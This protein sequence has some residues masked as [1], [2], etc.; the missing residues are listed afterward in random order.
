MTIANAESTKQGPTPKIEPLFND[1]FIRIFG[2]EESRKLTC[3]LINAIFRNV[4]LEEIKRGSE[5][6]SC[7][8][9]K[10]AAEILDKL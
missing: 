8:T 1:A 5:H 2:K 10:G 9:C 3:G 7:G 4:G 6:Y